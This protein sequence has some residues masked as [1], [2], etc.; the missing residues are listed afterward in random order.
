MRQLFGYWVSAYGEVY[1]SR[2][3]KLKPSCDGKYYRVTLRVDGR[4]V[5]YTTHA[6]VALAYLGP[7][8]PG[9]V[10][11]FLDGNSLNTVSTNLIYARRVTARRTGRTRPSPPPCQSDAASRSHRA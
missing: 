6:L 11:R 9:T 7:R 10:V 3:R 5:C 2:G 8:P 1:S 4:T